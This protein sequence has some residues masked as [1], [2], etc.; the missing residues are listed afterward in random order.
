MPPPSLVPNEH[1]QVCIRLPTELERLVQGWEGSEDRLV[2]DLTLPTP[3]LATCSEMVENVTY[4][5]AVSTHSRR[6]KE[7]LWPLLTMALIS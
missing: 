4:L 5:L 2:G 7:T 6:G 1:Q 3:L